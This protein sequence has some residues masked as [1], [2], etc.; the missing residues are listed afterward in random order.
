ML[1]I[2][3]RKKKKRPASYSL[4]KLS[5]W[6]EK[7]SCNKNLNQSVKT[8]TQMIHLFQFKKD[9]KKNH[10]DLSQV[11]KVGTSVLDY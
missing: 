10:P 7:R 8:T 9:L 3:N 1:F 2:A 6:K 4:G 11:L 5:S